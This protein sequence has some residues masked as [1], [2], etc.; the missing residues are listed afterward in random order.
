MNPIPEH[1][2]YEAALEQT[3]IH[4]IE[5]MTQCDMNCSWHLFAMLSEDRTEVYKENGR[6]KKRRRFQIYYRH[7]ITYEGYISWCYPYVEEGRMQAVVAVR[8]DR[9]RSG[10]D[11]DLTDHEFE[12]DVDLCRYVTDD[13]RELYMDTVDLPEH[14]DARDRENMHLLLSKWGLEGASSISLEDPDPEQM[15]QLVKHLI[16]AAILVHAGMKGRSLTKNSASAN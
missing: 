3:L 11:L 4:F 10:S 8:F 9:L 2:E 1:N 15:Q 6:R 7:K 5:S 12:M 13:Q 16:S 14:L